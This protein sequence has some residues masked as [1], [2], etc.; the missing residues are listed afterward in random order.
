MVKNRLIILP[1]SAIILL[2]MSASLAFPASRSYHLGQEAVKIWINQDGT[3]DLFYNISITLDAGDPINFVEVGQPNGDFTIGSALDQSGVSLSTSDV[4]SSNDFKVRVNLSQ[5]LNA[6]RTVWFTLTTNVA[7]MVFEDTM[8]P[9]NVGM[10]F[11]PT[12]W[13]EAS[14]TDLRVLIIL[15]PNVT[16]NQVKTL[17]DVPWN[18]TQQEPDGLGIFFEKL[19]LAPGDKYTVGVSFPKEYVTHYDTQPSGLL[20]FFLQY[21]PV[22]LI[23]AVF[24]IG[25][26]VVVS[27]VRKRGYVMPTIS[28]ESLGIRRGLTAVEA[29]YLLDMKPARIVTEILYSLLQ[30]RAVWVGSVSPSVKLRVMEPFQD[31]RGTKETPLRYYEIDFLNALKEDGTL[32][33]EKL[34]ATIMYLRD[35]VEEKMRGYRRQDTVDYYKSVVEKAWG[36]VEQAGTPELASEAYD[37]QLLWLFLDPNVQAHTQTAFHGMVFQ[38][39]PLWLWYWYGYQHY[40]PNPTY[41][42]SVE[43]L[44]QAAKPP[45][46]PGADFANNIATAVENTSNNI[47]VSLEKFANAILPFQP[48]K[49]SNQPAHHNADC[50]C[51][52]A[53]CACACACVSCACACAGGGV[54]LKGDGLKP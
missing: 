27:A 51:A 48:G 49:A 15:P 19:N 9:G 10:Q 53:A 39:S 16:T 54:G 47:V 20:A 11:T 37:E 38:P 30:K 3:I 44:S 5:P 42:P 1:F 4:S 13:S 29:S 32:N 43:T 40:Y 22:L 41:K 28:M 50:V 7:H 2:T 8:N 36:Q 34:A 6:G 18:N 24:V 35:T 25:A 26:V 12:Y 31:K 33:E 21:G 52:C 23:F 45:S 46:I 14:V 17:T